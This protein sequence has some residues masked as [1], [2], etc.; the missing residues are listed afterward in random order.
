MPTMTLL[1]E[2]KPLASAAEQRRVLAPRPGQKRFELALEESGLFPLPASAVHTLQV[3]VGKL[4]NQTCR[5]CHVDAGPDR[6]EVMTRDTMRLCL[7]ALRRHRIPVLDVTGGAPEMNPYFRW[8]VEE[9]RALGTHVID[10]C[11]LT[12]LLAPG[13]TD[14][15]EFLA[16]HRVEVVASLPCYLPANTDKQRGDGVFEKSIR[17]LRRLNEV[18]YGD[19]GLSLTL[20]YNPVGPSL[21][22]PQAGLEA[23]YRKELGERYGARFTRLFTITNMPVSRFLDDL[24]AAGRYEEYMAKLIEAY[25]PAAAAGVMCRTL[26]SVG[27]DGALYDC[28]FNQILELGLEPGAPRHIRDFDPEALAARRIVTGQHCY[29]CTAGA[30]SGCGGALV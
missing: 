26:V 18:G 6:R 4:C 25:N 24:L 7:D 22:P 30:G 28:D 20:V 27:W 19:G 1:R 3:N 8:L 13:F 16:E 12:I 23:A 5:H 9:T 17:A 14:L 21:P 15:P 29:G 11:N 10:R 2:G